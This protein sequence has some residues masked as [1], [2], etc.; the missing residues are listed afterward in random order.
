M[1]FERI[2]GTPSHPTLGDGSKI[3]LLHLFFAEK[4]VLQF[5]PLTRDAIIAS[6]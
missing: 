2:G 5:I 6:R 3:I 1:Y 4:Y